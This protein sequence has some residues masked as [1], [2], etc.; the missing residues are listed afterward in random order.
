MT[1]RM[2]VAAAMLLSLGATPAAAQTV[3]SC[4]TGPEAESITLVAMPEIIRQVGEICRAQLPATALVRQ[5]SGAFLNKYQIEADRAWPAAR[6]ALGR[7]GG[8]EIDGLLQSDFT[9]PLL[10]SLLAPALVGNVESKD[11]PQIERMA[12]LLQPLPARNTAGL[13]VSVLQMVKEKQGRASSS[14]QTLDLPICPAGRR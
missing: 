11:C 9:R 6:A 4:V 10:T 14:G 1:K 8:P 12:T 3:T 2:Q 7:V 5:T 13:V